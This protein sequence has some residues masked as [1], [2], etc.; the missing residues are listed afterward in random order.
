MW[1]TVTWLRR[2]IC[3]VLGHCW[4]TSNDDSL[5][6]LWRRCIRCNRGECLK[7]G[8]LSEFFTN[9]AIIQLEASKTMAKL[10]GMER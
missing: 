1:C 8:I 3:R 10:C 2:Q 7:R 4:R 5:F 6:G 9:M